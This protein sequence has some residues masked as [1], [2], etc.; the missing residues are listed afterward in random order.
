[1]EAPWGFKEKALHA[2]GVIA[3][4]AL[5]ISALV[6]IFMVVP[7]GSSLSGKGRGGGI[8]K[9][10]QAANTANTANTA[11]AGRDEELEKISEK[12]SE[13]KGK[14]PRNPGG[15]E[16]FLASRLRRENRE[17]KQTTHSTRDTRKKRKKPRFAFPLPSLAGR[18]FGK[19]TG[20]LVMGSGL[21]GTKKNNSAT[22]AAKRPG[23]G[24]AESGRRSGKESGSG[25]MDGARGSKA[26]TSGNRQGA[27][28]SGQ[29]EKGQTQ[30]GST[31]SQGVNPGGVES[32][33]PKVYVVRGEDASC[34][35]GTLEAKAAAPVAARVAML[36]PPQGLLDLAEPEVDWEG[37][38]RYFEVMLAEVPRRPKWARS[39]R[40]FRNARIH[41]A[42]DLSADEVGLLAKDS[43]IVPYGHVRGRGCR[44][45]WIAIGPRAYT[46]RRNFVWDRR[47]PKLVDQ[48]PMKKGDITPGRYAYI[49]PGGAPVY[50]GRSSV[51]KK[52]MFRKLPG[53]FFV[54]YKRFV[55]IGDAN[56][57]KTTKNW[58]IP[59]DRL[60]RH[61]PSEFSG[62]RLPHDHVKLPVAF[63]LR[64]HRIRSKPG[65][66]V[67]DKLPKHSVVPILGI[68]RHGRRRFEYYRVGPCRWMRSTGTRAAWPSKPP[69][70]VRKGQQWV[71]VNLERQTLVV[72]EGTQPVMATMVSTGLDE[73]PTQHGIF[74]VYWKVSETDMTSDM[75]A[76]EQYM[77]ESVPWSLFFWKGQALHGAYWHNSFGIPRSHGCINL[78]PRDARFLLEW[79]KPDLP[80]GWIYRWFGERFPG[81][82]LRV[83]RKD[84]DLVRFLGFAKKLAPPKAAK[85]R[86]EAYKARVRQETLELLK[87]RQEE[88]QQKKEK[89]SE[90]DG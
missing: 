58:Y 82:L 20:D 41:Y 53:G 83:R 73:H 67:V 74:R 33:E 44:G 87:K 64:A 52:D 2:F 19:S 22:G 80:K 34:S 7:K 46:C 13:K 1:M 23:Q 77:A 75:G 29:A 76:E 54:R 70:G 61:V 40:A 26:G 35:Q 79:S 5:A 48:P 59:V 56:Y 47:E 3:P 31:T 65:G 42:P 24:G 16:S 84:G 49:R 86:D 14:S 8:G 25:M 68:I 6:L 9:E 81:L 69:P 4:G 51:K 66:P 11:K 30:P 10:E 15:R 17:K 57:W 36:A 88:K 12:I 18:G 63:L 27:V 62:V 21:K 43:R 28:R 50:S 90:G 32:H 38:R 37:L 45:A 39:M 72:Y 71:D 60:A 78:A 55:R 85:R 89:G